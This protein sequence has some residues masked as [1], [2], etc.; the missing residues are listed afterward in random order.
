MELDPNSGIAHHWY[1]YMLIARGRNQEGFEEVQ[2]AAQLDP[3]NQ[4]AVN[5]V[6][7]GLIALKK[8]DE[9]FS[10]T[11]KLLD[12][13]PNSYYGHWSLGD[14]SAEMKRYDDAIDAYQETLRITPHNPGIVGR[15]GYALAMAGRTSEARAQLRE[16]EAAPASEY[17]SGGLRAFVYIGL[18]D[19]E[20]AIEALQKDYD[21]RS[22]GVLLFRSDF[23]FD[24]LRSD[25]RF[26]AL[27]RKAGLDQ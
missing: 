5:A 11:R 23:H 8:Y 12:L 18:R 10:R 6:G 16:L 14:L 17:S 4:A 13:E 7:S 3:L 21:R 24:A 20:R 19:R 26:E 22:I 9:A 1:G 15:L 27:I 25:P 2:K